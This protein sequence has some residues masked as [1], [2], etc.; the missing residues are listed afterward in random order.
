MPLLNPNKIPLV[1]SLAPGSVPA[2]PTNNTTVKT[3]LAGDNTTLES[4]A[5]QEYGNS[6]YWPIIFKANEGRI[7]SNR[8]ASL[9]GQLLTIPPKS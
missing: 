9:A 7:G 1:A 6:K 8:S 4:I 5:L 3:I 2:T